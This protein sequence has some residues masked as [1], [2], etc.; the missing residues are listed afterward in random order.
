MMVTSD[1]VRDEPM[2]AK[3]WVHEASRIF[4]DRLINDK[5]KEWFQDKIMELLSRHI[6]AKFEKD[7]IFGKKK[8]LFSDILRLEL[9]KRYE[10]IS[11][12]DKLKST[13]MEK[14]QDYNSDNANQMNLVFFEECVEHVTRISRVLR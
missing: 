1:S 4:H 11:A 13:L 5:D 14:L 3:L 9:D 6:K 8:I 7:V 10:N 12:M 2:V